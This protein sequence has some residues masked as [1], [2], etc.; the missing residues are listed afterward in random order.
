MEKVVFRV[1]LAALT[2]IV[3]ISFSA[4]FVRLGGQSPITT[5]FFRAAYSGVALFLLS[6]LLDRGRIRP[7]RLSR[8]AMAAGAA[9][10]FDLYFWH[11]SIELIGAGL[12][13]IVANTQVPFVGLAAWLLYRERPHA[14]VFFAIPLVLLGVILISGLN[15]AGAYG[16]DPI[17]GTLLASMAGVVY[18]IF[19]VL[20]R[21]SAKGG[22]NP[23]TPLSEAMLSAAVVSLLI[24][25][26][27]GGL[28]VAF[29]WPAHGW[30][31]ALALG[32]SVI[33]WGLISHAITRLPALETSVMLMLQP[34][35]TMLWAAPIFG[36]WIS[37]VQWAGVG[38]VISGIGYLSIR[39][40]VREERPAPRPA[41]SPS[42]EATAEGDP[43]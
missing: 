34:M 27:D 29:T 15:T 6:R 30:L 7:A 28:D 10:A 12:S 43:A 33:G 22:V 16:A 35:L 32:C 18:A 20:L 4:I 9:L 41:P 38:L 23:M 8:L 13:T 25:L 2:G 24:G 42:R 14:R 36:E 39:G 5:G 21:A 19:L 37:A 17:G 1:R 3:I 31:L 26:V 11:Q 40:S